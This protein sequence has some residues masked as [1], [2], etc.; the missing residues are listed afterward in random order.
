MILFQIT[1]TFYEVK[2]GWDSEARYFDVS[3]YKAGALTITINYKGV[4]K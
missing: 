2:D 1:K 4:I 3:G